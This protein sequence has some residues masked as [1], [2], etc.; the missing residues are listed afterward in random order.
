MSSVDLAEAGDVDAMGRAYSNTATFLIAL[1]QNKEGLI[2]VRR[3]REAMRRAGASGLN[4]FQAGYEARMLAELGWYQE[5]EDLCKAAEPHG[6]EFGLP[7]VVNV[8]LGLCPAVIRRGRYD[9]ARQLLD[10]I[11]PSA[12]WLG[13]GYFA[14]HTLTYDAELEEARGNLA[15]AR[16]SMS[17]AMR[18]VQAARDV[19]A[20]MLISVVR[21]LPLE[22]SRELLD[23][24][25]QSSK[26]P[27]FEARLAEAEGVIGG[28]PASFRRAADLYQSLEVPYQEARCRIEAGQLERAQE[29]VTRFGLENGPLAVRLREQVA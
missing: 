2:L 8:G 28:D 4:W 21:L 25:R 11:L 10:Y 6:T 17:E 29:I 5:A 24:I 14:V 1:L 27:S 12:R 15:A 20:F 7:G 9:E 16:Q 13:G 22:Q 26:H 23:R 19:G 18:I 3:G